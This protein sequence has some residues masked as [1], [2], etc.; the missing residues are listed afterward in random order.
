ME[1]MEP[2]DSLPGGPR[3][4][5]GG[6]WLV[7]PALVA[8]CAVV[9]V[10]AV[11]DQARAAVAWCGAAAVLAVAAAAYEAARRGR[12]VAAADR[13]A[14]CL[15]EDIERYCREVMPPIVTAVQRGQSPNDVLPD[16]LHPADADPRL[17]AAHEKLTRL[18]VRAVQDREY[19]RD[20][21]RRAIVNIA[22]R[23]QAEIHRLQAD[24]RRMQFK[25]PGPE[26]LGDLMHLEHG[27]NVAGRVATSL[28]VLGGGS[29]ARQ[30]QKPISLYDVLRAGSAPIA[31]YLR[32]DLHR[33]AEVAVRGPAVEP[34]SLVF[35]ELM[36]NATRY[37]PPSTKVVVN[38]EEVASGI[39]V[40][41]EDKGVGLTEETRRHAEFLLAQA[42]DGLDLEDLGET[43]RVGLRVVGIMAGR[44]GLRVSLRPSTCDGVRAVV[45]VPQEL[46]T[47]MPMDAYLSLGGRPP[48]MVTRRPAPPVPGPRREAAVGPAAGLEEDTVVER[49][50]NGLPQRRR[51]VTGPV[52]GP[53][54]A[55]GAADRMAAGRSALD[56]HPDMGLWMGAFFANPDGAPDGPGGRGGPAAP[57]AAPGPG[58]DA[59]PVAESGE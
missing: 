28:A 30:W 12:A 10:A 46:L 19:Q 42:L 31:E 59:E 48:G 39:E 20:S 5:S 41:I 35:S 8:A 9:A 16:R 25:H 23:I 47:A 17:V 27:V 34:L 26:I 21:A 36:D 3:A 49:N 18:V 56:V 45:F 50:A 54:G 15:L 32:I 33:I 6:V 4:A 14:E 53:G 55:T 29:P 44:L 24:L 58:P 52:T 1:P 13:R 22:C 37:S 2:A 57:D 7:P 11:T 38:T 43:A 51:R 40:S